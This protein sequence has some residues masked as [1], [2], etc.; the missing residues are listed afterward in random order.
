MGLLDLYAAQADRSAPQPLQALPRTL[1]ERIEATAGE[2]FSPDRYFTIES[3][4]RDMWQRSADEL[5][6]TTGETFANPLDPPSP[7]ELFRDGI[8]VPVPE[9][10]TARQNR[11][12]EAARLARAAGNDGLFDPENI[13]RYIGEEASRRRQRA[14]SFEGT[15]NGI[16][17]FLAGA[18][19]ETAT[20][21]GVVGLAIPVTRLPTAAASAVGR[22]FLGNVGREAAFQATANASLQAAAEGLDALSRGEVGTAGT[23]GEALTNIAGAAVFGGAIGGG[24]RAL[25]LK[26]LGLPEKVRAEAPTEVKD[27]FRVIEA[28]AI[29][30]GQNRLGVDPLLHERYQGNALDAV[31]RGRPVDLADLSRTADTPMTAVGRALAAPDA[32]SVRGLEGLG[33]AM[34]R[35]RALPDREIESFAREISPRSF[36]RLDRLE[37]EMATARA[38][39]AAATERSPSAGDL[40][41]TDTALRL[42]DIE[43]DLSAP[44]LTAKQRRALE[45]EREMIM[46]AVDPS[47][48]LGKQAERVQ[49]KEQADLQKQIEKLETQHAE[50]AE[51]AQTATA[52]LRRKLDRYSFAPGF[53]WAGRPDQPW[54]GPRIASPM[55]EAVAKSADDIYRDMQA[56]RRPKPPAERESGPRET[57]EFTEWF[58]G[59]KVVNDDGSPKIVYH[60]T[61]RGFDDFDPRRLGE[62]TDA[63]SAREGIFFAGNPDVASSYAASYN[64][65]LDA[66]G[67]IGRLVAAAEKIT[68]GYYSK[69]NEAVITLFG[70]KKPEHATP[71]IRPTYVDMKNPKVVDQKGAEYRDESYLDIIKAA[72]DEGHDG[73]I[74]RNT[75]DPGWDD[76]VGNKI[77]D[78]YVVFKPEQTRA[79]SQR[80]ETPREA[81]ARDLGAP[82]APTL[83]E[84]LTRAEVMRQA[85]L[86]REIMPEGIGPN[87]KPDGP[88]PAPKVEEEITPEALKALDA[89][90]QR[91][92]EVPAN[93]DREVS[94]DGRTM[95]AREALEDADRMAKDATAALN[96]A[97]GA[98]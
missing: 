34:D 36:E 5:F 29:Y 10:R 63:P 93:A 20:P 45:D 6:Q 9:I 21:H 67:V 28:E 25:H 65:Y 70:L 97:V 56:G 53:E 88:I 48:R 13:D 51:K 66:D 33:T 47:D 71:N 68:R 61:S 3:A 17:N 58:K 41:D 75:F 12:I 74:I 96:C 40:L 95:T 78:V 2:T 98:L 80:F 62:A 84:A 59:S 55:P 4:R 22:T 7:D 87:F 79:F 69:F 82:D 31:M 11:I 39:L 14:G 92:L 27:A 8:A 50:A 72:K 23:L 73:V 52:D 24:V 37:S 90:T 38:Q 19:L 60:G 46:A 16:G 43:R 18:V 89:E 77:T 49:R 32:V 85:R 83:G 1:G 26:W 81:I 76:E 94:I 54:T 30:S 86:V 64:P 42:Q 44:A 91:L 15:G 35:V 57:R